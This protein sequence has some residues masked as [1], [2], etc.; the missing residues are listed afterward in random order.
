M[1]RRDGYI[2]EGNHVQTR[3]G[4]TSAGGLDHSKLPQR[5]PICKVSAM[6]C[7][8]YPPRPLWTDPLLCLVGIKQGFGT[9]T[10]EDDALGSKTKVQGHP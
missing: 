7:E 5:G 6:G 3:E 9:T 10:L 1:C 4:S 8:W 2:E